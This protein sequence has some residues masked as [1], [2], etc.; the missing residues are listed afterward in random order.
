MSKIF[1]DIVILTYLEAEG[2]LP[3]FATLKEKLDG[4][5]LMF[6]HPQIFIIGWLKIK[7]KNLQFI[8]ETL[9][10]TEVDLSLFEK[11]EK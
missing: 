2:A 10:L 11:E 1:F 5:V 8:V 7:G 3:C 4:P 6:Y 9:Q